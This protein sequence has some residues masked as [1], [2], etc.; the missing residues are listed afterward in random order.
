M[1]STGVLQ[2]SI[3]QPIAGLTQVGPIDAVA[4]AIDNNP[5]P[6][7]TSGPES[8][9]AATGGRKSGQ[10]LLIRARGGCIYSLGLGSFM[11]K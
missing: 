9:V 8:R 5:T 6:T 11:M 4:V 2:Q 1:S 7:R 10:S 3:K